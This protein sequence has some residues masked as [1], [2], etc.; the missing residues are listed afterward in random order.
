[1]TEL[2]NNVT[3]FWSWLQW[4]SALLFLGEKEHLHLYEEWLHCIG[5]KYG[6]SVCIYFI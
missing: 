1:M 5:W 3:V 4:L 2:R 6:I